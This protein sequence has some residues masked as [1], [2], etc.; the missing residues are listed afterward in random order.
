[1]Y[2]K[3]QKLINLNDEE[4]IGLENVIK[5]IK[6]KGG[7]V[8]MMRLINDAI[9]IFIDHYS[10]DAVEKYSPVYKKRRLI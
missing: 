5:E 7:N 10:Q 8:S 2:A 4:K 3:Y 6:K 1:M 9:K